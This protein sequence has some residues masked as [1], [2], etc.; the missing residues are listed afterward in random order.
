MA[1][2]FQKSCAPDNP[3]IGDYSFVD[4]CDFPQPPQPLTTPTD[5]PIPI[6]PVDQGCFP[7][8]IQGV[9]HGP[10]DPQTPATGSVGTSVRYPTGD[11][12][13]PEISLDIYVPCFVTFNSTFVD[14]SFDPNLTD[15]QGT[16]LPLDDGSCNLGLSLSIGLPCPTDLFGGTGNANYNPDIN[17]GRTTVSTIPAGTDCDFNIAI[18][19]D[20]PCPPT[21]QIVLRLGSLDSTEC[22]APGK[23][24]VLTPL[25]SIDILGESSTPAPCQP[26][27]GYE[28]QIPC[29]IQFIPSTRR[30][31]RLLTGFGPP[32]ILIDI[33]RSSQRCDSNCS[34]ELIADLAFPCPLKI[35]GSAYIAAPEW[36]S[37]PTFNIFFDV[38]SFGPGATPDCNPVLNLEMLLPCPIKLGVSQTLIGTTDAH[39]FT[40]G[41]GFP[42][43]WAYG[44]PTG[45]LDVTGENCT[46]ELTLNLNLPCPVDGTYTSLNLNSP[47]ADPR[48]FLDWFGKALIIQSLNVSLAERFGASAGFHPHFNQ[49]PNGEVIINRNRDVFL[50][51]SG[52]FAPR[53]QSV[54]GLATGAFTHINTDENCNFNLGLSLYI[55]CGIRAPHVKFHHISDFP[56]FTAPELPGY[57]ASVEQDWAGVD[58]CVF[59]EILHLYLNPSAG[60]FAC[61]FNVRISGSTDTTLLGEVLDINFNNTGQSVELST[62]RFPRN[63]VLAS[64]LPSISM[65]S[66]SGD[67][68]PAYKFS[69]PD[70][71]QEI[72]YCALTFI[73]GC[74]QQT[75]PM[76]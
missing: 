56:D 26:V 74:L 11:L 45:T 49:I 18:D 37:A 34:P 28:L 68:V 41:T 8:D 10:D 58:D 27:F 50:P 13:E 75:Q 46:P 51:S 62:Y 19:V 71:S 48:E 64:C 35:V 25:D 66:V 20:L 63:D 42:R 3:A 55:P 53:L 30:P 24:V 17:Q 16:I 57:S 22:L 47:P 9:F 67:I 44:Q 5:P 72:W 29:P 76:P 65:D 61:T 31:A 39:Y 54:A 36:V 52:P 21:P 4:S 60:C 7:I 33:E 1:G 14:V 23:E 59:D 43:R 70:G 73:G 6:P 32:S 40:N 69:S 38:D 12:C 2:A 15:A